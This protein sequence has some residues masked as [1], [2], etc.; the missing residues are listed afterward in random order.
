MSKRTKIILFFILALGLFLRVYQ[1]GRENF[2]LDEILTAE[3]FSR[4]LA[5]FPRYWCQRGYLPGYFIIMHSWMKLF[6]TGEFAVRFPSVVFGVMSIYIMFLLGKRLFNE[7][8]G[9]LGSYLFAVSTINIYYS[10]WAKPYSLAVLFVLL[11]F[12]FLSEALEK[13]TPL[14][15]VSYISFTLLALF[16]HATTLPI[17]MSQAL[18]IALFWSRYKRHIK[19]KQVVSTFAIILLVYL[20]VL[21]IL[22]ISVVQRMDKLLI[23]HSR[24][25]HSSFGHIANIFNLFGGKID[26]HVL[27]TSTSNPDLVVPTNIFGIILF[28]LCLVGIFSVFHFNKNEDAQKKK[29][30]ASGSLLSLWIGVP[31]VLQFFSSWLNSVLG[32]VEHELHVSCAYYL[33]VSKGVMFFRYK[34]RVLLILF[35]MVMGILFIRE[36]YHVEKKTNWRKICNYIREN[37]KEDE[38]TAFAIT[39]Y[40]EINALSYYRAPSLVGIERKE[41]LKKSPK[42]S[43]EIKHEDLKSLELFSVEELVYKGIW[44]VHWNIPFSTSSDIIKILHN[45]YGL[46]EKREFC[47]V[48]VYHFRIKE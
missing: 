33:L 37:I 7:K 25:F 1:L 16:S 47:D 5:D 10:Q 44:F 14:L 11:S 12:L 36:Y 26:K 35:I 45:N 17:L 2:F 27:Y 41:V 4:S 39:S 42:D 9:L 28:L 13:N 20:P 19:V 24:V 31:F 30:V 34:W 29:E 22:L 46:V 3:G 32:S 23:N 40:G 38:K 18:F 6:G 8:V 15:W 48:S 21:L 43:I